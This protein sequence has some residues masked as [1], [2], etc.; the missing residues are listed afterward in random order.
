MNEY[1]PFQ[2]PYHWFTDYYNNLKMY[3]YHLICKYV[4]DEKLSDITNCT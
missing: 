2:T 4:E 1:S 3:K